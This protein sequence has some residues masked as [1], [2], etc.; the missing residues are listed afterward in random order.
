MAPDK[1]LSANTPY[2][3]SRALDKVTSR[4]LF[5]VSPTLFVWK[6]AKATFTVPS[7]LLSLGQACSR[8]LCLTG[9]ISEK[10]GKKARED[11]GTAK[12]NAKGD[13]RGVGR[14]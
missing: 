2:N 10:D 12:V 7:S 13:R 1:Y 4:S 3:Y 5:T 14:A 6:S 8:V 11:N 9:I